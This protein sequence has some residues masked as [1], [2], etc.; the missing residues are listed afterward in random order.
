MRRLPLLI[1]AALLAGC[2]QAPTQP[3]TTSRPAP[4]RTPDAALQLFSQVTAS[5]EPVAER[6]CRRHTTG[7]NCD[8]RIVLDSRPNQPPNAY[9]TL[10]KSGRPVLAFTPALLMDVQNRHELAFVMSHEAAHHMM[11]HL[12][13]QQQNAAAGAAVFAGLAVITGGTAADV[14]TATELGAALGARTYSKEY[15]LEA[16]QLGTL[17]A[18]R[19]GYDPLL[20]AAYFTRIPD[21]GNRFLG[22]HP[23]NA[24]RYE[25]VRQTAA[26]LGG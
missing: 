9:Q 21:P 16:D 24:E 11:Q 1:I 2:M 10:E 17:I 18:H 13:R 8:F 4:Q 19:A 6:E 25:A 15:E 7:L 3:T 26:G 5:V 12:D 23:P 14:Q 20:G 22:T